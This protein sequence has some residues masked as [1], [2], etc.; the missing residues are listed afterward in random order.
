MTAQAHPVLHDVPVRIDATDQRHETDLMGG[1]DVP[2]DRYWGAQTQRS[3]VHFSIGE[4]RKP[5]R[6]VHV[7]QGPGPGR[8]PAR[9]PRMDRG[10]ALQAEV[11][12]DIGI[13]GAA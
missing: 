5:H 6:R 3:L 1:I 13:R 2:A 8:A 9:H 7:R 11:L 10:A 12:T 4:D